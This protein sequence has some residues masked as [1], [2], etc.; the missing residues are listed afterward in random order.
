MGDEIRRLYRSRK[1][2]M[3]AGVCAGLGEYL[4]IDPTVIRILFVLLF[5]AGFSGILIYLIMLFIIPEE[6]LIEDTPSS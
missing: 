4:S 3:I 5:L 1:D 6:P 2:R